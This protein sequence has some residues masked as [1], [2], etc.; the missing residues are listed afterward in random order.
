MH[1]ATHRSLFA[2]PLTSPSLCANGRPPS[3]D[4][5]DCV[6]CVL[7]PL[8]AADGNKTTVAPLAHCIVCPGSAGPGR[9]SDGG[10]VFFDHD[11]QDAPI[12]ESS[13]QLLNGLL[14]SCPLLEEHLERDTAC[15]ARA[16]LLD[17]DDITE[18]QE[19][20]AYIFSRGSLGQIGH[21]SLRRDTRGT[22]D[23]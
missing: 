9:R 13:I 16:P 20:L 19:G 3:L 12:R 4:C 18:L 23:T 21:K 17:A 1:A 2:A 5:K 10:C 6:C 15:I 7:G 22:T 11:A 8:G 14:G